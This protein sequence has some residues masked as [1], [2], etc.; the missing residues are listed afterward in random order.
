LAVEEMSPSALE[1]VNDALPQIFN[2]YNG[3]FV[4][5][6]VKDLLFEGI[7]ICENGGEGDFAAQMICDQ[8]KAKAKIAKGMTIVDKSINYSYLRF[9]SVSTFFG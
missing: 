3:L 8:F 4:S 2:K 5:S 9:V 7:I 6:K 1:T